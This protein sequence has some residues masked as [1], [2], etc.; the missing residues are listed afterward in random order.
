MKLPHVKSRLGCRLYCVLPQPPQTTKSAWL[1]DSFYFFKTNIP[2]DAFLLSLTLLPR[3]PDPP[4]LVEL[5]SGS[6]P[7]RTSQYT[8]HLKYPSPPPLAPTLQGAVEGSFCRSTR[9]PLLPEFHTWSRLKSSLVHSPQSGNCRPFPSSTI[10][11]IHIEKTP[12]PTGSLP[13]WSNTTSPLPSS[14]SCCS[15]SSP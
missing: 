6:R 1:G 13:K 9:S 14:S 2:A 5:E 3:E 15:S 8:S 10:V 12:N 11:T 7:N 4:P